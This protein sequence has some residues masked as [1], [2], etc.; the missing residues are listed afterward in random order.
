MGL[1]NW[2]IENALAI[3]VSSL[4][5]LLISNLFFNKANRECL[6]LTLI[7]PI[8]DIL[9]KEKYSRNNFDQ[10]SNLTRTYAV[11]YLYKKEKIKLFRLV[12]AYK[13]VCKYNTTS[14]NTDCIMNYFEHKLI[15]NGINP[16]P[17]AI[18]DE[19]GNVV[20][21]DFPPDYNYLLD[22]VYEVVASIEFIES[23]Y[24]SSLKIADAFSKYAKKYY[25]NKNIKY[26]ED[27]SIEKV[28]QQSEV[29]KIWSDKFSYANECKKEF[30]DLAICKKAKRLLYDQ[31][32]S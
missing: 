27:L 5:S 4:I 14:A 3:I 22:Y 21:D 31:I 10:I 7:F 8:V 19:E 13:E 17:C 1:Y 18:T 32:K 25:S 15:E 26:F 2:L 12:N 23:P 11:K 28:I 6:L 16:K 20:I 30:L 24:E 9:E 29:S